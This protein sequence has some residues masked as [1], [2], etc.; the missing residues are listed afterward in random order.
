MKARSASRAISS[1]NSVEGRE[2]EE[3]EEQDE[4]GL[5]IT[6]EFIGWSTLSQL[7]T[8]R[9]CPVTLTGVQSAI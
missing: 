5:Q 3:E 7:C 9:E 4:P 2:N 6:R 1:K 8:A